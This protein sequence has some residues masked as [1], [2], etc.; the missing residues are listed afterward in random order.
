MFIL[1]YFIAKIMSINGVVTF[2]KIIGATT[3]AMTFIMLIF[4]IIMIVF[5]IKPTEGTA[6][7]ANAL[8]AIIMMGMSLISF[9]YIIIDL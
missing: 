3:I 7:A 4:M 9:L 1:T 8:M 5:L 2:G 6:I